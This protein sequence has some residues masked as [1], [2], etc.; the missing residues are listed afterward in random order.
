MSVM[1][2]SLKSFSKNGKPTMVILKNPISAKLTNKDLQILGDVPDLSRSDLLEL[3]AYFKCKFFIT[4]YNLL[5]HVSFS[6]TKQ[7]LR[8]K[9]K[10]PRGVV[11]TKKWKIQG[12]HCKIDWKSRVVDFKKCPRYGGSFQFHSESSPLTG[13]FKS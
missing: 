13:S 12:G 11:S 2:Y 1:Q 5:L 9:R 4:L 6:C 8:E 7:N 10:F 3:R